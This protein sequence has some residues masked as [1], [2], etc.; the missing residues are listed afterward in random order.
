MTSDRSRSPGRPPQPPHLAAALIRRLVPG[1]YADDFVTELNDEFARRIARGGLARA[2]ARLWYWAQALSLN[3]WRLR[4]GVLARNA[5][6]VPSS[7]TATFTRVVLESV[8]DLRDAVRTVRKSPA[9]AATVIV[10]FALAVGANVAVFSVVNGVLLK[11]LPYADPSALVTL[12]RATRDGGPRNVSFPDYRD[13]QHDA[14]SLS[15]LAAYRPLRRETY[16]GTEPAEEWLG[17]E[18]TPELFDV[19]GVSPLLGRA[20]QPGVDP[21][22]GGASIVLSHSLWQDRFNSDSSVVGQTIPF[23]HRTVTVIG[24]MPP[25]FYFPTPAAQYWMTLEHYDWFDNRGSWQFRTIGRLAPGIGVRQAQ[26]QLS[27]IAARIDN[28][29]EGLPEAAGV[30]LKTQHESYVGD[31]KKLFAILA[32]AVAVVLAIACANI[33]NLGLT[34]AAVRR[35]EFAIRAA[36]GADR[37]RL[38]RQLLAENV[39][40]ALAGAAAGVGVARLVVRG[41][42]VIGPENLPRQDEIGVDGVALLFATSIAVLCGLMFG[43]APAVQG[44]RS[45]ASDGL[46]DRGGVTT[47][48]Q[49]QRTLKLLLISQIGLSQVLVVAAGLLLNSFVRLSSIRP[50]FD[51]DHTLTMQIQLPSGGY[52]T[53]ERVTAFHQQLADQLN[54]LPGTVNVG[55]TSGLPFGRADLRGG[56]YLEGDAPTVSRQMHAEVISERYLEAM[57]IPIVRGRRLEQSDRPDQP[58]VALI[59]QRMADMHWAGSDPIGRRFRVGD[60][61][62]TV[63]GVVGTVLKRGLDGD[64][65]PVAYFSLPQFLGYDQIV[66]GRRVSLVVRSAGVPEAMAESVRRE[67]AALDPQVVVTR[68]RSTA[69]LVSDSVAEPRFQTILI[70]SF[71][72]LALLVALVGIYG[73]MGFVVAQRNQEIG[74]RMALGASAGGVLRHVLLGGA[75]LIGTGLAFGTIAAVATSRVLEGMLFGVTPADPVT[76]LTV[77]VGLACVALGACYL[78]AMRASRVDPLEA[79]RTE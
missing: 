42:L 40:L 36:V 34:R 62:I 5:R 33:A 17:I 41:L 2:T 29:P 20:L 54:S 68:I 18:T 75:W 22:P 77:T 25:G 49:R 72:I 31:T 35:R 30:R 38:I 78:P 57:G 7:A 21:P 67:I 53:P 59:N 26:E 48:I 43:L 16:F 10:T 39:V 50:G 69:D 44:S 56:Y 11:P 13:F 3:T 79:L 32:G 15:E 28:G 70:G 55:L 63:I 23:E 37:F 60:T 14:T 46:R 6:G 1:S 76:F 74:V 61:W 8:Q 27:V 19:L 4:R 65:H 71:A 64:Q 24:V 9:Y 52:D 51:T 58:L 12:S 73:V 66:T 47:G 45:V